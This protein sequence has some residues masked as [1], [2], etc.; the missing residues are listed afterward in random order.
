MNKPHSETPAVNEYLV[1]D[2]EFALRK[3]RN[4]DDM[5]ERMDAYVTHIYGLYDYSASEIEAADGA[6]YLIESARRYSNV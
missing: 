4:I 3:C 5:K 6:A 2:M 1:K